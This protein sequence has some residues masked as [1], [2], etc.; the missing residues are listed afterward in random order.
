M[1]EKLFF[2]WI[3][4]GILLTRWNSKC[5]RTDGSARDLLPRSSRIKIFRLQAMVRNDVNH[6]SASLSGI[7]HTGPVSSGL[8]HSLRFASAKYPQ[9]SEISVHTRPSASGF[10]HEIVRN[11]SQSREGFA[12]SS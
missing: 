1:S 10:L 6:F 3:P 12:R 11:D 2:C 4:E 7:M 9:T 5:V 8:P